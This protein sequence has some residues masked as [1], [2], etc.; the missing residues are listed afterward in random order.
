MLQHANNL[1]NNLSIDYGTFH[2]A[3]QFWASHAGE[4]WSV[5]DP[6]PKRVE[7]VLKSSLPPRLFG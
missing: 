7:E 4:E 1:G 3:E 2:G 6:L 5:A